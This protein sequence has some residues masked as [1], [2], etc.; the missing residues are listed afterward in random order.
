M[1]DNYIKYINNNF[2]DNDNIDNRLRGIMNNIR[3]ILTKLGNIVTNVDRW[4]ITKELY[5]L[6][7]TLNNKKHT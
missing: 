2:G 1:E 7:Q 6:E 5:E 4:V 3:I